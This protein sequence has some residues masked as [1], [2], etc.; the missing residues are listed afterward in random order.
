MFDF[1]PVNTLPSNK[2]YNIIPKE[3]I[4]HF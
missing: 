1:V 3:Y 4:S 2:S